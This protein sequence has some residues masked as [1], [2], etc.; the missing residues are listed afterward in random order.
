[1]RNLLIKDGEGDLMTN[2]IQSFPYPTYLY[3]LEVNISL[4][5]STSNSEASASELHE[6]IRE[7]LHQ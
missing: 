7:I 4:R 1:M 5:C 3:K 2:Y 6:N